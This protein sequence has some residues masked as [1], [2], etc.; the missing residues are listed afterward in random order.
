M[1]AKTFRLVKKLGLKGTLLRVRDFLFPKPRPSWLVEIEA[2]D[3]RFDLE[4]GLNTGGVVDLRN[5][6]I[7]GNNKVHGVRHVAVRPDEFD[8][9]FKALPVDVSGYTFIDL[10]SG[11]GRALVLA[12]QHPF[13][14]IIGVEFAK[15]L[16]MAAQENIKGIDAPITTLWMDA[17]RYEFPT[18]P[19]IVFLYNPFAAEIMSKVAERLQFAPG[20]VYVMYLNPFEEQSWIDHGFVRIAK[21]PTFSILARPSMQ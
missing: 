3:A 10:G 4:K 18:G 1:I 7:N 11:K 6:T 8:A 13:T 12:A 2:I 16:H 17:T 20:P 14:T 15:E 5:L 9:A 19:L 21:G